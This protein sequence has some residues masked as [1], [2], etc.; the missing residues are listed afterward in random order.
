MSDFEN[1]TL[2]QIRDFGDKVGG[3]ERGKRFLSGELVLVERNEVNRRWIKIDDTTIAVDLESSP[4]LPSKDFEVESHVGIGGA[5]VQKRDDGLYVDN[6][7]VI[8]HLSERQQGG[9][10]LKGYELREE[11]TGKPVLN[12]NVLDALYENPYLIPESWKKDE[13]GKIRYIFFWGTIF[14]HRVGSL[15][16]RYLD[17]SGRWQWDWHWLGHDWRSDYPAAVLAGPSVPVP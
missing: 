17:F 13:N 1:L 3:E 12:A 5:I 15:N 7:K 8:L 14:R 6:L 16:V 2:K 11:L 9:K 4:K 10:H